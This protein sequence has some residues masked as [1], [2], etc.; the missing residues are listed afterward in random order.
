MKYSPRCATFAACW[1]VA[2]DPSR[3]NGP[4]EQAPTAADIVQRRYDR[5]IACALHRFCCA[6][7]VCLALVLGGADSAAA[8]DPAP[9]AG[10]A[11]PQLPPPGIFGRFNPATEPFIPD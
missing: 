2:D 4:N 7:A 5:L 6:G 1:R 3:R 9:D 8:D 11:V 10:G